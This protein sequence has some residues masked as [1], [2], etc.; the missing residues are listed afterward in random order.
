[1]R[2]CLLAVLA[3]GLC[4]CYRAPQAAVGGLYSV[5]DGQGLYRAAKVVAID[6]DGIHLRLFKNNWK[7]RPKAVD[8]SSLALGTVYDSDGFGIGHLAL[9]QEEFVSWKPVLLS[10]EELK[11]D[12]VDG[13]QLWR[14]GRKGDFAGKP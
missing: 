14:R 5:Q 9:S 13:Y 6:E 8:S 1:M 11:P 12:E 3:S 2:A 10:R 4:G 7:R